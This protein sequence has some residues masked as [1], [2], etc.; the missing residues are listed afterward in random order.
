MQYA[1]PPRRV[2]HFRWIFPFGQLVFCMLL[3]SI[4]VEL[5]HYIPYVYAARVG[6]AITAMNLPGA[7]FQVPVAFLFADHE[8]WRPPLLSF[9]LW[10]GISFSIFALVFWWIA[11]RATEALVAIDDRQLNPKIGWVETVTGFLIMAA[12]ATVLSGMLF[13][14][15]SSERDWESSRLA[16]GGG[17]WALLGS[18]SVIARFRQ[19]RFTKKQK[20][21]T[22]V[23]SGRASSPPNPP[24]AEKQPN[25]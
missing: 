5:R 2:F 13:G 18:L 20:A 3:V 19:W 24:T 6:E 15:S 25:C 9:Q 17:L 11:G 1:E 8:I 14:L 12:G 4:V 16:A 21:A 10:H 23:L 22:T 7:L